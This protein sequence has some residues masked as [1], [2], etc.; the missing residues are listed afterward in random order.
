MTTTFTPN[1]NYSLPGTGD[2]VNSWGPVINANFSAIDSNISAQNVISTTG[3][4][5][6]LTSAQGA[7]V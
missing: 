5:T 2:D 3:G 4:T 6:T 1:K 7:N